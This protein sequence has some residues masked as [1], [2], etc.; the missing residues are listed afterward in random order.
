M[1]HMWINLYKEFTDI[2]NEK[3]KSDAV[4][5]NFPEEKSYNDLK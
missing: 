2:L 4:C 1:P 5:I 3:Y